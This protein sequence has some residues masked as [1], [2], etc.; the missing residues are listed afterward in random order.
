VTGATT[1]GTLAS[2]RFWHPEVT[3][4]GSPTHPHLLSNGGNIHGFGVQRMD[5]VV[6]CNDGVYGSHWRI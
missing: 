1:H 4:D 2:G 3:I 6:D 5:A